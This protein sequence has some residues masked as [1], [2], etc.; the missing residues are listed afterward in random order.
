MFVFAVWCLGMSVY[1]YRV[2]LELHMSPGLCSTP[3]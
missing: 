3:Q 2:P 1:Q